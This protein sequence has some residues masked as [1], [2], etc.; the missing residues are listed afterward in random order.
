MQFISLL[1]LFFAQAQAADPISSSE[2]RARMLIEFAEELCAPSAYFPYCY[3]VSD[4]TCKKVAKI[5]FSS[6]LSE[7]RMPAQ[8]DPLTSGV[9]Y[10]GRLGRCVGDRLEAKFK[11]GKSKDENCKNALNW[12]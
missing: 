10:S 8:V 3:T 9:R 11:S 7:L 6:C 12:D 1:L 2:W 4:T 5:E